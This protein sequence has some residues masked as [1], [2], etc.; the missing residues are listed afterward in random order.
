MQK[1]V[2]KVDG[3]LITLPNNINLNTDTHIEASMET[4]KHMQQTY[5]TP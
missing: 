3:R 1:L 2:E 4:L 5:T